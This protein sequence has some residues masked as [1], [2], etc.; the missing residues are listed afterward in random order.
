M[1]IL[2]PIIIIGL[3]LYFVIGIIFNIRE[4]STLIMFIWFPI[5]LGKIVSLFYGKK[6]S[7]IGAW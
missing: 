4:N 6:R 2:E 5:M 3:I 7:S 1:E